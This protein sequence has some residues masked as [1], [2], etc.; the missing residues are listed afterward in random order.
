MSDLESYANLINAQTQANNSWSAEQA[1]KQME[2]QERMSSTAHQRE[3]A[4]L[5]AAGLNPVLSANQGASTPTGAMG[6]TDTGNTQAITDIAIQLSKAQSAQA[7]ANAR[8]ASNSNG[9]NTKNWMT[10]LVLDYYSQLTGYNRDQIISNA[11][12]NT[13]ALVNNIVSGIK[14]GISNAA[15]ALSSISLKNLSTKGLLDG[16]TSASFSSSSSHNS[17]KVVQAKT[18]ANGTQYRVSSSGRKTFIR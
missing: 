12:Q 5:K 8:A 7:V 3:V 1:L 9:W 18:Y 11:A 2:F 17:G 10:D 16:I 13:K 15:K 4:D 14:N 6:A